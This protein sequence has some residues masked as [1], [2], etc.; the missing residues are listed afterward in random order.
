MLPLISMNPSCGGRRGIPTIEFPDGS[1]IRD[2]VAII[3][4]FERLNGGEF[5]PSTPKQRIVSGLLDA[6]GAEGLLRPCMHYR[7]NF[8]QDNDEFLRFHFRTIY[9]G[10]D[11]DRA[12]AERSSSSRKRLT[13]PGASFRKTTG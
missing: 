8:D 1:V 12:A 3:D 9:S 4:H 6:I 13:P 11:A 7:W 5:S 2:G 10:D